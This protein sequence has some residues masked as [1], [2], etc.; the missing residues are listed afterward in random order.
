[1]PID[2]RWSD[3][4]RVT[5]NPYPY[6]YGSTIYP[7]EMM[8][9]D[10]TVLRDEN[11]NLFL[12]YSFENGEKVKINLSDLATPEQN[13]LIYSPMNTVSSYF[14]VAPVEE[15]TESDAHTMSWQEPI[16][17]NRIRTWIDEMCEMLRGKKKQ[18]DEDDAAFKNTKP[19]EELYGL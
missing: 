1:M 12:Q 19:I 5:E 10:A 9:R 7:R 17:A 15:A 6:Q 16:T 18:A 11:N 2:N 8:V 4:C 13:N 14:T 3:I